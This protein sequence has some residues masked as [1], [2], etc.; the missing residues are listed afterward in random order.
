MTRDEALKNLLSAI[1]AAVPYLNPDI[2]SQGDNVKPSG[3]KGFAG[4]PVACEG[5]RCEYRI[6][7]ESYVCEHDPSKACDG[8][9]VRRL[10]DEVPGTDDHDPGRRTPKVFIF[11]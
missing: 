6:F 1:T 10:C 3:P 4:P 2:Q 8:C 7:Y 11:T 5:I 9:S